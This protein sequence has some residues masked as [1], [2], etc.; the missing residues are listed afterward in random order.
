M[1][2]EER[3]DLNIGLYYLQ[4]SKKLIESFFIGQRR[5]KVRP[6]A[7]RL[8]LAGPNLLNLPESNERCLRF[9]TTCPMLLTLHVSAV[10]SDGVTLR[11]VGLG[12]LEMD[13]RGRG[14]ADEK[15]CLSG[16]SR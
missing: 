6:A 4:F 3:V 9:S 8:R 13:G 14:R 10:G 5:G 7:D 16:C 1:W 11:K 2:C 12:G 15:C